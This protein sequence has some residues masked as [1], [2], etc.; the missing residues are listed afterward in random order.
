M[1]KRILIFGWAESVHIQR[2]AAGLQARGYDI[3][4]ISLGGDPLVEIPT[5]IF[6]RSGRLAYARYA[7]AAAEAA[8]EFDPDLVHVHYAAGFGHWGIRTGH[9]PLVVS[10][11][12]SDI[13]RVARRLWFRPM[14]RKTLSRADA[15]TATSDYLLRQTLAVAPDVREK[16]TVLPWGVTIPHEPPLPT[17]MPPL[18]L[19]F[20]KMH[21]PVYGPDTLLYAI[22]RV[23]AKGIDV[24]LTF[25]GEGE[26]TGSLQR[27][28][29]DLNL[30][31]RVTFPGFVKPADV[32]SL[33]ASHHA[34]VMPSRA[35]AFGVA[36]LE[37]AAH[38][39]PTLATNVGG[40]PEVVLH[41]KTGLLVRPEDSEALA[42]GIE[43]LATNQTEREE[44]GRAAFD[45]VRD[46][47]NWQR[48]LDQMVAL[49]DRLIADFR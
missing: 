4:V 21:R 24:T 49:Y 19:C 23:V 46:R 6:P 1:A 18:K 25:A 14:I 42:R 22:A 47:Y 40:I 27:L 35:E 31:D 26:M 45:Y 28:T 29:A 15:V 30:A 5:I 32:S 39:R 48:S 33:L 44:W 13:E 7:N 10:V 17:A 2:W 41:E 34:L 12:G 8:R 16:A 3:K 20:L 37:A 9:T 38:G 36:A 11:W 43:R